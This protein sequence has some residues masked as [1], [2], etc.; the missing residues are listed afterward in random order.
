MFVQEHILFI[1]N[2]NILNKISIYL[3]FFE[4]MVFMFLKKVTLLT[5]LKKYIL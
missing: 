2:F 1:N 3:I 4:K 5:I